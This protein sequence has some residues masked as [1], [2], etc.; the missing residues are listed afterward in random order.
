MQLSDW[1]NTISVLLAV[2]SFIWGVKAW[3]SAY[4]GQKRIELA[5]QVHELFIR[6]VQHISTIRDPISWEGEGKTRPRATNETADVSELYDRAFIAI[7][8]FSNRQEDFAKLVSLRDRCDLYFGA[9]SSAPIRTIDTIVGEVRSASV[10]LRHYWKAQGGH[11]PSDEVFREHLKNMHEAEAVIWEGLSTPD[12]IVLRLLEASEQ[13]AKI[14]RNAI[15]PQ[16]NLSLSMKRGLIWIED[17]L[18]TGPVRRE[19]E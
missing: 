13:M 12:P 4:L 10:R 14:C 6:C 8:R 11:F 17:F 5:E 3:R 18:A 1:I 7:E 2:A 19:G 15:N 9:G 16:P